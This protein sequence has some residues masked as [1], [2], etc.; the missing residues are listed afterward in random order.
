M[1]LILRQNTGNDP[2][3]YAQLDGNF[4]YFTGSHAITGSL[5]VSGNITGT[6]LGTASISN[7]SNYVDSNNVG[8]PYGMGSIATASYAV[9][10]NTAQ[11]AQ[12]ASYVATAQTAS[13]V[14]TAQTAL[15]AQTA[16]YVA[17]AQTA[18][19]V[20]TAQTAQTAQTAS[21]VTPL[22]QDVTISGSI[23]F[24]EGSTIQPTGSTLELNPSAS[25]GT[26]QYI[27][28]DPTGPNHIHVRAGGVIDESNADLYLGGEKTNI[29][30]TD[31]NQQVQINTTAADS[32]SLIWIFDNEGNTLFPTLTTPR[33]DA[34]SGDLTTQTLRLGNGTDQAVI[35]TPDGISP[36]Y[37]SERLVINPGQ[38]SGSGE[39][40]DIYLWA[41]R[42]GIDNGSGG[43]I[44]VRGGYGPASGS[45]GYVRI[46][47]GDT[48]HGSA[49]FVEISGGD[50]TTEDGGDVYI[51][52]GLVIRI[53]PKW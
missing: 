30:V 11:T 37:S 7:V 15:T 43:D 20:A 41:G 25:S 35:T 13:Y 14:A 32:S 40:G 1:G 51:Y 39:G 46:Q 21:Y 28:L 26:D 4:E 23:N 6:L 44:K 12:T 38:G 10:S 49:G 50:S 2:L 22:N 47:G 29:L 16:S 24:G 5:V 48:D 42:G 45:G 52:G 19:Y 34:N 18:S 27:V 33:G 31:P 9:D 53:C 17:T 36:N 8:G 3:T